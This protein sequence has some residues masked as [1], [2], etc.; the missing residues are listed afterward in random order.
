MEP[1]SKQDVDRIIDNNLIHEFDR[2]ASTPGFVLVP[3]PFGKVR[4]RFT[5][6]ATPVVD[7]L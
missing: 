5:G 4:S 2:L 1:L 7:D 6:A 3:M